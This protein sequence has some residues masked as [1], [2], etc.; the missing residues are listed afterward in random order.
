MWGAS[1]WCSRLR[2]WYCHFSGLGHCCGVSLIP[3]LGTSIYHRRGQKKMQMRHNDCNI[4]D[5][6]GKGPEYWAAP[7]Q[8]PLAS[9]TACQTSI[10]C[11]CPQDRGATSAHQAGAI[12]EPG[13]LAQALHFLEVAL[14]SGAPGDWHMSSGEWAPYQHT[15]EC[16]SDQKI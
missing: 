2:T 10:H 14:N 6:G 15:E 16:S 1:L 8:G 13:L 11:P 3:G 5:P 4:H 7:L 12:P 9:P